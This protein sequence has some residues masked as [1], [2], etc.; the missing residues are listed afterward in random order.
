LAVGVFFRQ[1]QVEGLD[2]IP[3]GRCGLLISWHPNGLVDPGLILTAFPHQVVF[4]ARHGLFRYPLLGT[5]LRRIGTVPIYR[6]H[7]DGESSEAQRRVANGKSLDALASEIARGSYSALFPEGVSHDEPHLHGLKTGAARLYYRARQM[8]APG[9]PPPVIIPV[10]LHY[11]DKQMFRSNALVVFHAP[12]SLSADLDVTPSEPIEH[13]QVRALARQLTDHFEH[14]LREVVHATDDWPLYHLMHRTRRLVRAERASRVEADPG[15]TSIGERVLGFARVRAGYYALRER[16]PSR[17]AELQ[18][19]VQTYDADL[20]ALGIEDYDLDRTPEAASVSALSW[21]AVQATIVFL[22][23][24]PLVVFGYLTNLPTAVALALLAKWAARLR[25]D[26]AT[27]K[28]VVGL[29]AFPLTWW[30]VGFLVWR[31]AVGSGLSGLPGS[32]VAAGLMASALAAI[33]GALGVRYWPVARDTARAVRVR[34]TRARRR[35][36]ILRLRHERAELTERI[37]AL[38]EGVALP[39]AVAPDGRVVPA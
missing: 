25:K 10:G 21:L 17:V 22:L 24:P 23:L 12:L 29:L 14:T 32:P 8:Q 19:R 4:G 9:A 3:D 35:S 20:R 28:L 38:A 27:V 11:D 37:L 1:V 26:E 36:S 6:A 15:R 31:G 30:L 34:F 16:E 5:L 33:G 13:E 39:G 2:R 18:A 7:D